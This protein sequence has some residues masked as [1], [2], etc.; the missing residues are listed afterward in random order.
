MFY[1]QFGSGCF[2]S[3]CSEDT[4]D[5]IVASKTEYGDLYAFGEACVKRVWEWERQNYFTLQSLNERLRQSV[6]RPASPDEIK[7]L[8][9]H[10]QKIKWVD[11]VDFNQDNIKSAIVLFEPGWNVQIYAYETA[12]GYV[13]FEWGTTV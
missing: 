8:R 5:M 1:F 12:H 4:A 2:D 13:Y 3:P 9:D 6:S 10:L 7:A 11:F